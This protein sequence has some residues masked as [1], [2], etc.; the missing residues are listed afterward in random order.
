[1]TNT[2]RYFTQQEVS[3][4]LDLPISTPLNI[5]PD[6]LGEM[7]NAH[8]PSIFSVSNYSVSK[9]MFKLK[10][11]LITLAAVHLM[12]YS[13]GLC[14]NEIMDITFED[15][16]KNVS[17]DLSGETTSFFLYIRNRNFSC[18]EEIIEKQK[19]YD[20]PEQT[21]KILNVLWNGYT[22]IMKDIEGSSLKASS[23]IGKNEN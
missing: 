13:P 3:K 1:M 19:K 2:F 5:Y 18:I 21:Y 22:S 11:D 7:F 9:Y 12:A 8:L 6:E 15:V 20:I 17:Y 23:V 14:I 4:L 16:Y 10:P